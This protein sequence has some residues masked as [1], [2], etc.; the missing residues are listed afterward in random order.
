MFQSEGKILRKKFW[1]V[2]R[3]WTN[4]FGFERMEKFP[5]CKWELAAK[6]LEDP[7]SLIFY[8]RE[9]VAESTRAL[10]VI[11]SPLSIRVQTRMLFIRNEHILLRGFIDSWVGLFLLIF[12]EQL[13]LFQDLLA[14][15]LYP[16]VV[17]LFPLLSGSLLVLRSPLW[18]VAKDDINKC[19]WVLQVKLCLISKL[20]PTFEPT[21]LI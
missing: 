3:N 9:L 15:G 14:W 21:I 4:T 12:S 10:G 13:K 19:L 6:L 5:Y 2:H 20:F 17:E 18:E 16:F 7:A 1:I 8:S 11:Q